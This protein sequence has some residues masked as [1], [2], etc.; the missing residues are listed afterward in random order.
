[1]RAFRRIRDGDPGHRY[2]D[3]FRRLEQ[4]G[5]RRRDLYSAWDFTI[6]TQQNLSQRLLHI[7]NRAF[8]E[9]GDRDLGD[10]QVEGAAPQF[11]V[12]SVTQQTPDVKRVDGTFTIRAS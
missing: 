6:A 9:P 7:R 10:L 11:T 12:D 4:A 3:I 8:A 1:M 5:I 2:A